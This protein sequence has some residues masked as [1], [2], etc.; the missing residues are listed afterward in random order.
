MKNEKVRGKQYFYIL[1]FELNI[2][3]SLYNTTI[4][5]CPV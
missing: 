5:V 4:S 1:S 3:D 2:F